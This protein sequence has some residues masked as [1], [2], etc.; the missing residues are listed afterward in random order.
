MYIFSFFFVFHFFYFSIPNARVLGTSA[1]DPAIE[2]ELLLA[3]NTIKEL[4]NEVLSYKKELSIAD[5]NVRNF[6]KES[7]KTRVEINNATEVTH[8]LHYIRILK[9]FIFIPFTV[10]YF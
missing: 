9:Y 1:V 5:T 7:A 6:D 8:T 10:N 3:Q 2:E 4:E